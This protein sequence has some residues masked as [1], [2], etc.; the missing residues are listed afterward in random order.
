M[1]APLP[2]T[3]PFANVSC[4]PGIH[5]QGSTPREYQYRSVPVVESDEVLHRCS[6]APSSTSLNLIDVLLLTTLDNPLLCCKKTKSKQRANR[7]SRM[8]PTNITLADVQD[9]LIKGGYFRAKI[10]ALPPFDVVAGGLAWCIRYSRFTIDVEFVEN[11]EIRDKIRASENICN[12]LIKMNCTHPLEPHQIQGLDYPKIFLV[13]QWLMK[14]VAA[15]REENAFFVKQYIA[16]E[17]RRRFGIKAPSAQPVPKVIR[18]QPAPPRVLISE[19]ATYSNPTEHAAAV[20][21]EY[22]LSAQVKDSVL[23]LKSNGNEL[24]GDAEAQLEHQRIEEE[25]RR[26]A[27]MLEN[28]KAQMTQHTEKQRMSASSVNSVLASAD[29]S[30]LAKLRASYESRRAALLERLRQEEEAKN[31]IQTQK[32]RTEEI[33]QSAAEL[34]EQIAK[35][36]AENA[37]F[38]AKAAERR[39]SAEEEEEDIAQEEAHADEIERTVRG[40][41][42]TSS[43][44]DQLVALREQL[45]QEEKNLTDTKNSSKKKI[46]AM[47]AECELLAAKLEAHGA[48]DE[49]GIEASEKAKFEAQRKTLEEKL[50]ESTLEAMNLLRKIDQYPTRLELK[51]YEMRIDEL[52]EEVAWKFEETR[53]MIAMHNIRNEILKT[54]AGEQKVFESVSGAFLTCVEQGPKKAAAQRSNLLE[55]VEGVVKQLEETQQRQR[56]RIQTEQEQLMALKT[57]YASLMEQQKK[58]FEVIALFKQKAAVIAEL[59]DAERELIFGAGEVVEE[60]DD[61]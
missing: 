5:S 15:T 7:F 23:M 39:R 45:S 14:R 32:A 57:Q 20:L 3:T 27:Q 61:L 29:S 22:G 52:N 18:P 37:D 28:L 59:S 1:I 35:Q 24:E 26:E 46:S 60:S 56:S 54:L 6:A 17:F 43:Q 25:E 11:A 40:D 48:G 53:L 30:K 58:Y 49:S 36:E 47:K 51:Q 50:K 19:N 2:Y 41:P 16:Q 42:T 55:Q 10:Q 44:F 4:T 33:K 8:A 9:V 21:L 34:D 38:E 31:E 13:L 12:A